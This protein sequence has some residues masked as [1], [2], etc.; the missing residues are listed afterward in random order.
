MLEWLKRTDCKSVSL[1][2]T[3][4]NPVRPTLF[5]FFLK[6]L[7]KY[8]VTA[9]SVA[10]TKTV[11]IAEAIERA[12]SSSSTGSVGEIGVSPVLSHSS[13]TDKPSWTAR[14]TRR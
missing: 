4:S 1:A 10:T 5:Y 14:L 2:Y 6:N 8:T 7:F 9:A 3:G 12:F 13:E 11:V